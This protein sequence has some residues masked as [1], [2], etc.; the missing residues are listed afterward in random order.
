MGYRALLDGMEG[1]FGMWGFFWW[2]TG[3]FGWNLGL[4]CMECRAF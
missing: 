2:N 4:F 3:S 1:F